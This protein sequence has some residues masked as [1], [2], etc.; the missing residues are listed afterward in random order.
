MDESNRLINLAAS[1]LTG[2]VVA[3]HDFGRVQAMVAYDAP[4]FLSPTGWCFQP[5]WCP[6]ETE[7][8][9]DRLRDWAEQFFRLCTSDICGSGSYRIQLEFMDLSGVALANVDLHG[10]NLYN[11]IL[12]NAVLR[13]ADMR[14]ANLYNTD[15]RNAD[16]R[17]ADLSGVI[18]WTANQ[19]NAAYWN[20]ATKW[21]TRHTPRCVENVPPS[22]P[23]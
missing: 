1:G 6:E 12:G 7:P 23:S 20:A 8:N 13:G 15:L 19:L 17:G 2:F 3:M 22:S 21:P 14:N 5:L 10:A 9:K 11:V 4:S 18:Y 16:L